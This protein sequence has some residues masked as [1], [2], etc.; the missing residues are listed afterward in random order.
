MNFTTNTGR[1]ARSAIG[2]LVFTLFVQPAQSADRFWTAAHGVWSNPTF[3]TPLG[4]PQNVDIAH[5]GNVGGNQDWEIL[6]DQND[7]VAG[8]SISNGR[9]FDTNG[10]R[11]IVGGNTLV[12]GSGSLLAIE[13]GVGSDDFDTNNLTVQ[14]GALVRL[15]FGGILDVHN[16]LTVDASS[17]VAPN[18]HIRLFKNGG[19]ALSLDGGLWTGANMILDQM[20][21]GRLDLDGNFGNSQLTVASG[22]SMTMN[23]TELYDDF[24]GQINLAWQAVLHMNMSEGWR[25]ASGGAIRFASGFLAPDPGSGQHLYG[26]ELRVAGN[27]YTDDDNTHATIHAETTFSPTAEVSVYYDSV[28]NILG[29]ATLDGGSYETGQDG[30]L[31][32]HGATTIYGGSFTSFSDSLQDGGTVFHGPTTWSGNASIQGIAAQYGDALVQS[33]TTIHGDAFDLD[34]PGN[35][36]WQINAPLNLQLD[37]ID[38][39]NNDFHGT[40][41]IGG[42][43]F[44]QLSVQLSTPNAPWRMAGTL[45]MSG[46]G[47]FPLYRVTGSP[48]QLAGNVHV[49]SGVGIAADTTFIAG[50]QT[51]FADASST[52]VLSGVTR[53]KPGSLFQGAGTLVNHQQGTMR[54][55]GG[56]VVNVDVHNEGDLGFVGISEATVKRF[57][58]SVDGELGMKLAGT[59]AGTEHDRLT[60]LQ[61]VNLGGT[62]SLTP[63]EPTYED[64]QVAGTLDEFTLITASFVNGEFDEV[65][66]N[67][68]V[69]DW[70]FTGLDGYRSH[71]GAG[72]FRILDYGN[73]E[74]AWMNYRALGGDAN[75]DGSVDGQDFTLWNANK[76]SSGTDWTTGDFNG[77]GVTDG[78]DFTIWNSNKFTSLDFA[79]RMV[80][81]PSPALL[82]FM[83]MALLATRGRVDRKHGN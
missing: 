76:F 62:L 42:N 65:R 69:M 67:D 40:F 11:L 16:V 23:G 55:E 44:N 68:Q 21:T 58:Q 28:L 34:G 80:P 57:S 32:L 17:T 3:W 74:V 61:Q 35:V 64:P 37:Y 26:G 7:S 15:D 19:R 1:V 22:G 12:A 2:I 63:I 60:S 31:G 18:G 25:V 51:Q 54:L 4:V 27:V 73:T 81:E 71:E 53:I 9:D 36:D 13:R 50:N 5:I 49:N 59:V 77:D 14:D 24:N 47:L 10:H 6:L 45:N 52:L 38:D 30:Q 82:G 43:L 70:E 83:A 72:L 75:G 66:Y 78:Q 48:V 8:L 56:S 39:G 46:A 29:N 41:T 79:A 20:G 33:E